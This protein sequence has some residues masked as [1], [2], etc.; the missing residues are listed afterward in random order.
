MKLLLTK[1]L[2]ILA[3]TGA[4]TNSKKSVYLLPDGYQ[5]VVVVFHE[6]KEGKEII[7]ENNSFV[8]HIPKS[9]ILL[10]N[11]STCEECTMIKYFYS[12]QNPTNEINYCWDCKLTD[13]KPNV[14]GGSTG[15]YNS[16]GQSYICTVF[17]VGSK[18]NED[19]LCKVR[20]D[21]DMSTLFQKAT[22]N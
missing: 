6:V 10:V 19:S 16:N 5:G 1:S 8:H 4:C 17:I 11:N 20:D 18:M 12:N 9:G 2:I 22:I 3:L 13:E 15:T 21:L 14:F 7:E